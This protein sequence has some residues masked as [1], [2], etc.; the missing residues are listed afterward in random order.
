MT[1]QRAYNYLYDFFLNAIVLMAVWCL[2]IWL[3]IPPSVFFKYD[4]VI[5][6]PP[7]VP[8]D[9]ESIN[10]ESNV[11]YMRSHDR[12]VWNDE[13][14][15]ILDGSLKYYYIDNYQ[16]ETASADV[17]FEPYLSI[18][19]W[20]GSY[21]QEPT[22]CIMKSTITQYVYGFIPKQQIIYSEPFNFIQP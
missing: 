21:P 11:F 16:T 18:W 17:S 1:I 15:C 8:L 2:A 3:F 6:V 12:V 13:L 14:R 20:R 4:T 10:M 9:S 19:Q 5:A 22:T 7:Q